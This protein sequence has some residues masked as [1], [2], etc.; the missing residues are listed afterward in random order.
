MANDG[1]GE[2]L[3]VDVAPTWCDRFRPRDFEECLMHDNVTAQLKTLV[4]DTQARQQLPHIMLSGPSGSGKRTRAAC[5]IAAL[6]KIRRS[7]LRKIYQLLPSASGDNDRD[8]IRAE[9]SRKSGTKK[10][11]AASASTNDNNNINNRSVLPALQYALDRINVVVRDGVEHVLSAEE[12]KNDDRT[13]PVNVVLTRARTIS[14]DKAKDGIQVL[15]S[16]V[17]VEMTPHDVN[18]CDTKIVQTTLKKLFESNEFDLL[19]FGAVPSLNHFHKSAAAAETTAETMENASDGQQRQRRQQQQQ[20]HIN[21]TFRIFVFNDVDRMSTEAQTALRRIMEDY[22]ALARFIL[23]A[24]SLDHVIAPI[25]SRCHLITVPRP[26][27]DEVRLVLESAL[28]RALPASLCNEQCFALAK[29][30]VERLAQQ[31]D[32]N[33]TRALTVM[34]ASLHSIIDKP[35]A[36]T[37][38]LKSLQ[39]CEPDW[40]LSV[41]QCVA[42]ICQVSMRS[43]STRH[44]YLKDTMCELLKRR[45]P[46]EYIIRYLDRH[47]RRTLS[48]QCLFFTNSIRQLLNAEK[49]DDS[50]NSVNLQERQYL[51]HKLQKTLAQLA[52]VCSDISTACAFYQTRLTKSQ[53]P[54]IHVNALVLCLVVI[55]GLYQNSLA[56]TLNADER[57]SVCRPYSSVYQLSKLLRH[58]MQRTEFGQLSPPNDDN[59]AAGTALCQKLQKESETKVTSSLQQQVAQQMKSMCLQK[60]TLAG[61]NWTN[62]RNRAAAEQ[63]P[64]QELLVAQKR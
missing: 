2:Q 22:S 36:L 53:Y 62:V 34:H 57:L 31:C 63:L 41:R 45:V 33:V 9:N 8:K 37:G 60:N 35:Q 23:I 25:Q 61:V 52:G 21:P 58:T 17:H 39:I 40:L 12:Q 64:V 49:K 44:L 19:T 51:E 1:I 27:D 26:S 48:E 28:M 56:L 54:I 29:P 4:H 13:V 15:H 6:Y 3:R 42:Q 30:Y 5:L 43:N 14:C 18:F 46:T 24:T 38:A 11:S 59:S 10:Q 20:Q 16:P 7:E 47:I 55:V 50:E 32:G